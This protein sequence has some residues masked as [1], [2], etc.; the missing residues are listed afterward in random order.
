[1]APAA[2]AREHR[3][4][5]CDLEAGRTGVCVVSLCFQQE[6]VLPF[7]VGADVSAVTGRRL[8]D[9]EEPLTEEGAQL[10]LASLMNGGGVDVEEQE[11]K[12]AHRKAVQVLDAARL[13]DLIVPRFAFRSEFEV[14][15]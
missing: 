11:L 8:E 13:F 1:M 14:K 6:K 7:G 2:E 10:Q 12:T 3:E 5:A 9:V 15:S 4:G